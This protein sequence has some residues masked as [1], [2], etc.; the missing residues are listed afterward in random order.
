MT[1]FRNELN[2]SCAVLMSRQVFKTDYFRE[3][4]KTW[5]PTGWVDEVL[6]D[7]MIPKCLRRIWR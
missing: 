6:K 5:D 2:F 3:R 7:R 1:T 4:Q